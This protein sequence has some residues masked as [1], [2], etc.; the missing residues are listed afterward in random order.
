MNDPTKTA[1]S[2]ARAF[3]GAGQAFDQAKESL[4]P[5]AK[6]QIEITKK[7]AS[8]L[9][10]KEHYDYRAFFYY[11][12]IELEID[13]WTKEPTITVSFW[14]RGRCGDPDSHEGSFKLSSRI[15]N[16]EPE[17]FEA[18]LRL[19]FAAEAEKTAK[20]TAEQKQREIARLQA[21][22]AQL[23]LA[24]V[25]E[26]LRT[27]EPVK[28]EAW[29]GHSQAEFDKWVPKWKSDAQQAYEYLVAYTVRRTAAIS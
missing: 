19:K 27:F 26:R 4:K 7:V 29:E 11:D 15:V 28:G 3:Y 23:P 2:G 14:G 8:E 25:L 18:E 24:E 17:K 16:G 13:T 12:W 21:E 20:H 9:G 5:L 6:Q 1:T 10:M 22:L